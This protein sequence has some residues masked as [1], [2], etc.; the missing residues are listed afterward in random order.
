MR[1]RQ[2]VSG[3]FAVGLILAFQM[4]GGC[5]W[6]PFGADTGDKGDAKDGGTVSQK[7]AC[8]DKVTSCRLN[9]YKADLGSK[10]NNCCDSNGSLCDQGQDYSFNA[11][12]DL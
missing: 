4:L 3:M 6:R 7:G 1:V 2:R 5:E 12:L 10:C 9:C 11:C 8:T